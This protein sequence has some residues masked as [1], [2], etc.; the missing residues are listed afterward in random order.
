MSDLIVYSVKANTAP[1]DPYTHFQ[2]NEA[3]KFLAFVPLEIKPNSWSVIK[4]PS[5]VYLR[6]SLKQVEVRQHYLP[7]DAEKI[8]EIIGSTLSSRIKV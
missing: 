5:E 4:F 3:A 1:P 2:R 8:Y 6:D 7:D